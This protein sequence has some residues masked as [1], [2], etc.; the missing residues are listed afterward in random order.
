FL[1]I[2]LFSGGTVSIHAENIEESV[3]F[4]LASILIVLF[5]FMINRWKVGKIFGSF[6]IFLY[7]AYLIWAIFNV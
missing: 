2:I 1:L 7:A 6:L 3:Y 5:F 4:L